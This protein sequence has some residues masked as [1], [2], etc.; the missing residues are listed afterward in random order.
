MVS[1]F[2]G[3]SL[4]DNT[5]SRAFQ[6]PLHFGW[7]LKDSSA[8][9]ENDAAFPTDGRTKRPSEVRSKTCVIRIV[10]YELPRLHFQMRWHGSLTIEHCREL[11]AMTGIPEIL[12]QLFIFQVGCKCVNSKI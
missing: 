5:R 8:S 12:T 2:L 9:H 7:K 3:F 4:I 6:C 10:R 1:S 11:S